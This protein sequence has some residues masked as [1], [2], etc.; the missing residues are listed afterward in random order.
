[1]F[2]SLQS[3]TAFHSVIGGGG[4]GHGTLCLFV[5]PS[6]GV[7]FEKAPNCARLP[8]FSLSLSLFRANWQLSKNLAENVNNHAHRPTDGATL[9]STRPTG[10]HFLLE[11]L[12]PPPGWSKYSVFD[13][14]SSSL[15]VASR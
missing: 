2:A 1:M 11:L 15:S 6:R 13:C 8:L 10:A 7:S 4:V 14:S 5:Q 9:F 12:F 3:I